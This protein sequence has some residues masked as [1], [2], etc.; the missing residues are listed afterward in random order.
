MWVTSAQ[1]LKVFLAHPLQ[2]AIVFTIRCCLRSV[3]RMAATSG[4]SEED[5]HQD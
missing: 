1:Q 2:Y 3:F 4:H 5:E